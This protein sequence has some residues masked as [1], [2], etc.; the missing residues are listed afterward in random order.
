VVVD[1][2][3]PE[4]VFRTD[5]VEAQRLGKGGVRQLPLPVERDEQRLLRHGVE[6]A[7]LSAELVLQVARKLEG[8]GHGASLGTL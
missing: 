3:L 7:E 1:A 5:S 4:D 2:V 6:V 8:D